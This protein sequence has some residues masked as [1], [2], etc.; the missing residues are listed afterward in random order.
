[1]KLI[2]HPRAE[3]G[4]A[5]IVMRSVDGP[6]DAWRDKDD[7]WLED[8]FAKAVYDCEHPAFLAVILDEL[9]SRGS[10]S[11]LLPENRAAPG[12]WPLWDD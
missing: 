11:S 10:T 5:P 4:A 8:R 3:D 9:R 1:M 2:D 7:Q 6:P 12:A